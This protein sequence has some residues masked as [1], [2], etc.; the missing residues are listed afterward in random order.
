MHGSLQVLNITLEEEGRKK[1]KK[2]LQHGVFVFG[3]PSK[4]YNLT[5]Q[6]LTLLSGRKIAAV[7]ACG[8]VTLR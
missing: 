8:L 6:G 3:N 4:Y 7:L 1:N 2:F 5:E